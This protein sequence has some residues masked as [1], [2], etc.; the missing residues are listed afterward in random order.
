MSTPMPLAL[1]WLAAVSTMTPSPDPRS[2]TKSFS[3]TFAKRSIC[4]LQLRRRHVRPAGLEIFVARRRAERPPLQA[5]SA[6][7]KRASDF[8]SK[9]MTLAKKSSLSPGLIGKTLVEELPS[10]PMYSCGVPLSTGIVP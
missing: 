5:Q 2:M 10:A 4:R 6:W 3:L 8:Q 9:S 7:A 1:N